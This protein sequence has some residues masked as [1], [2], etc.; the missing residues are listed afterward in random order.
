MIFGICIFVL[1]AFGGFIFL[2]DKEVINISQMNDGNLFNFE[3]MKSII[4][5]T[6]SRGAGQIEVGS[7]RVNQIVQTEHSHC[8]VLD[9]SHVICEK[10]NEDEKQNLSSSL[11][12]GEKE[13]FDSRG[14][15]IENIRG[16]PI[17]P[18][19]IDPNNENI[20]EVDVSELGEFKI[21][22]HSDIFIVESLVTGVFNQTVE[23]NGVFLSGANTEGQY[24]GE[25]LDLNDSKTIHNISFESNQPG[26]SDISM[27]IRTYNISKTDGLFQNLIFYEKFDGG[28]MI[29]FSNNNVTGNLLNGAN[30][31]KSGKYDNA[32][33][34]DG[35]NDLIDM[36][37][38]NI[39]RGT[40]DDNNLTLSMWIKLKS[41]TQTGQTYLSMRVDYNN[42]HYIRRYTSAG[43]IRVYQNIDEKTDGENTLG[44]ILTD[45]DWHHLVIV[46]N[47]TTTQFY[48]DGSFVTAVNLESNISGIN[49]NPHFY[50]GGF[51]STGADPLNAYIDD[52]I[53]FNE[54]L[55]AE[56]I[57]TLYSSG[58]LQSWSSFS[59]E[60]TTY[61]DV[62]VDDGRF[63]QTRAILT[64]PEG[65]PVELENYTIGYGLIGSGVAV[66]NPPEVTLET[67][68]EKSF[69]YS[70]IS[71]NASYTD[72]VGGGLV[73]VTVYINDSG[74]FT[75]NQT[76]WINGT[77][78]QTE[79]IINNTADGGYIWNVFACDNST[80]NQCSWA[81][82]NRSFSVSTAC[83]D[84]DCPNGFVCNSETNACYTSCSSHTHCNSTRYCADGGTCENPEIDGADCAFKEF[85]DLTD[86]QVCTSQILGY[87]YTDNLGSSGEYCTDDSTGCVNDGIEYVVGTRICDVGDGND[88]AQCNPGGDSATPWDLPVEGGVKDCIDSGDSVN[89][90]T[91]TPNIAGR[92]GCGFYSKQT[93][94]V[95]S[96][97]KPDPSILENECND[98]YYDGSS[99]CLAEAW[100]IA[101]N[102]DVGCGA[103]NDTD[104][105]NEAAGY[106]LE[107]N[108][109]CNPPPEDNAPDVTLISPGDS[110]TQTTTSITFQYTV[111]D[112]GINN[113]DLYFS[114]DTITWHLNQ[115]NSTTVTP[116][117]S[118]TNSFTAVNFI[119]FANITWNVECNDTI[120][121]T[122]F[123]GN[124][125][126][127]TID[128][129]EYE[130]W[131]DRVYNGSE[132]P[133]NMIYELNERGDL[134]I[135]GD[136]F[137]G[138]ILKANPL[139]AYEL[140]VRDYLDIDSEDFLKVRLT[141]P[142]NEYIKFQGGISGANLLFGLFNSGGNPLITTE[143][144]N[145]IDFGN[146][147]YISGDLNV[148]Q[149]IDLDGNLTM[150]AGSR[151]KRRGA[152]SEVWIDSTGNFNIKLE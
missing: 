120:N 20:I 32:I 152:D 60:Y 14:L 121:Q 97:C 136:L 89:G 15:P 52:V 118:T 102:C 116:D 11:S 76:F 73:N 56:N 94:D 43:V 110:S 103:D 77:S 22:F 141:N 101:D 122:L 62:S 83:V 13:I 133:N 87:C 1:V 68:D 31:T 42:Y 21:G 53:L 106:T 124:N 51:T 109:T 40:I 12:I 55:S 37:N 132:T 75:A 147:V 19:Y 128:T 7:F 49:G 67:V 107:D 18:K 78:N 9:R 115:T 112:E 111:G 88:F 145:R 41:T 33:E 5:L 95:S 100:Q 125:F 54:S 146:G 57:S 151:I 135:S 24:W 84:E 65:D 79:F 3:K 104:T 117:G 98:Y 30:Y 46:I 6:P 134:N 23:L 72:E 148:S 114:T 16:S 99:D 66:D 105:C 137:I 86:D 139:S 61:S 96:G 8:R 144:G 17:N 74:T 113:C 130:I 29:D 82:A 44:N 25:V 45:T 64:S 126:T 131:T 58:E 63:V 129:T 26:T 123:A 150:G 34:L 127:F 10:L 38:G 2:S 36:S 47:D 92:E 80:A 39:M 142:H 27:A 81:S 108:C 85:G 90:S 91:G 4:G 59:P 50:I 35:T 48:E 143:S 93:C 140:T 28:N 70:N 149:S 71:L 119:E 138:G 69:S